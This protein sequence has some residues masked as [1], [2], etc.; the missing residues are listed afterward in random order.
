M[1]STTLR[2]SRFLC[3]VALLLFPLSQSSLG[4]PPDSP[5]LPQLD[6]V[7]GEI[8]VKFKST[9]P[10]H[11]IAR[12]ME[13]LAATPIQTFEAIDAHHW[14]LGRGMPVET[15]L[16]I[17]SRPPFS[18]YVEYAE[19]NAILQGYASPRNFVY[20]N[21]PR[22]LELYELHNIGLTGGAGDAD[23][24]APEAWNA[25][26]GSSD[27]VV[28][29]IDSGIDYNH[30]DLA[31]NIWVNPR[32]IPNNG[33]DDDGNGYVDDVRG[34]DFYNND[35]DPIDDWEHGTH[36]AGIIGG[37][38]NNGIG[39]T[40]VAWNVKLLPIKFLN[41]VGVGTAAGATSS[42]L[43][44]A[45]LEDASGNKVVKISNNSWGG[46]RALQIIEDAIAGSDLLFVAAAGNAGRSKPEYPAGYDLDNIISVA[47][48]D[49]NDELWPYSNYSSRRDPW[50]DLGAPGDFILSTLLNGSYGT[51]SGTSMATPVVSGVAA[52][53]QSQNLGWSV[54]QVRDQ[55]LNTV[56]LLPGLSDR[57]ATGG[58]V[59]ARAALGLPDPGPDTTAPSAV[60]DL[61]LA[62]VTADSIDVTWTATADDGSDAAS[63]A[64]FFY[65][66]R[67]SANVPLDESNWD[68][69]TLVPNEPRPEI[70][71]SVENMTIPNLSAGTTFY[72][73]LRVFDEEGNASALANIISVMTPPT[74]AGVWLTETVGQGEKISL[75]YDASGNPAVAYVRADQLLFSQWNGSAW[76]SAV[77][78]SGDVMRAVTLAL[79]PATGE[80]AVS[81]SAGNRLKLAE[82]NGSSWSIDLIESK[83]AAN[84][85]TGLAFDLSGNPSVAYRTSGR[86][87]SLHLAR[88][89]GPSW[90]REEIDPGR[91][92]RFISL[93]YDPSG[94]P[95]V[96]YSDLTVLP[97]V[98]F[99]DQDTLKYASKSGGSWTVETL[100]A[101]VYLY[102]SFASLSFSPLTGQPAVIHADLTDARLLSF[103]GSSWD[104]ELVDDAG[105]LAK[106]ASLAYA[107]DGTAHVSYYDRGA[108]GV[109][110]AKKPSGAPAWDFVTVNVGG[111]LTGL[112]LALDG[113]GTPGLAY[114]NGATGQVL[115]SH[116][117]P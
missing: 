79:H 72:V 64:A 47:A 100:E 102:G 52:L 81:Y 6:H 107:P 31:D 7:P 51:R 30:P 11:G 103:N 92:P 18:D 98:Y 77:V 43:Y 21:D 113:T 40:G 3:L 89:S 61:A 109:I 95:A 13:R 5:S 36:V 10:N 110:L 28:A 117:A 25:Q 116:P 16:A 20:P 26:T 74:P 4:S 38:G 115:Y 2:L 86:H 45:S 15:A 1:P 27:V 37:V 55:I 23:I 9:A 35:N 59:N 48:T 19:P 33:I 106:Q 71:G 39:I 73:G 41:S 91:Q 12:A 80:P 63:G 49:D 99:Y 94:N 105:H 60:T 42:I 58:R 24:D 76:E 69:A 112:D 53:V 8:L 97:G 68:S 111:G 65:D 82:R 67:V 14:K 56:D 54:A 104:L 32:E 50:V 75:R 46:R 88:R 114:E 44:A 70:L 57:V 17:L 90:S 29:V 34:W 96:A 93:A 85:T 66:L 83:G 87:G 78:D 62:G 22:A 108:S 84:A 101:G